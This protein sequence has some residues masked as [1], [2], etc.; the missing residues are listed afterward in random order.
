M[1]RKPT[2]NPDDLRLEV[3]TMRVNSKEKRALAALARHLQR[4]RSDTMRLLLRGAAR[5]LG[6]GGDSP[7]PTIEPIGESQD[8]PCE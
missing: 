1:G 3:F 8:V 7:E 5:E 6:L 2:L 4:T